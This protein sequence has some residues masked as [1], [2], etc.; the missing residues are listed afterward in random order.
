VLE[1][2]E[3]PNER[4]LGRTTARWRALLVAATALQATAASAQL[5]PECTEAPLPER[6]RSYAFTARVTTVS[7]P[8]QLF[9]FLVVGET[10]T[11]TVTL[12]V[13]AED[14][15]VSSANAHF[16][17]ALECATVG[18]PSGR[19]VEV[20]NTPQPAPGERFV[21]V[22]ND[23]VQAFGGGFDLVSDGVTATAGGPS[24]LVG[25]VIPPGERIVGMGT[26][27]YGYAKGCLL[28]IQT[29]CPPEVV[30]NDAFPGPPGDTTTLDSALLQLRFEALETPTVGVAFADL[31]SMTST[32]PVLC[33]EP[34]LAAGLATSALGLAARRRRRGSV[35]AWPR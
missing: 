12:D 35:R 19:A 33:P 20:V 18:F 23:R 26:V 4:G 6:C 9:E 11:G 16:P 5:E 32:D 34:G 3:R 1:K 24:D 25:G 27:G 13:E 17:N 10:V 30:T 21:M 31:E 15:D 22:E 28:G 7:D 2:R 14:I 29:P 8:G